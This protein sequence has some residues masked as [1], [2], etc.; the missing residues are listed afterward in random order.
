LT[1]ISIKMKT[2]NYLALCLEQAAQ[3]PLHYRHGA[4]IVRGGKVI[5]KG[6]N[7]YRRGYD[8]GALKTG[9]IAQGA[10]DGPAIAELKHKMKNKDK[11]KDVT[12]AMTDGTSATFVP[13][14]G[15]NGGA[16]QHANTPLSMHSEMMAIHSALAQSSTLASTT[17]SSI[18]PS[19]KLRGKSKRA[20]RLRDEQIKAY[21]EAVC[22]A[23]LE[24][25][26]T[27]KH[28]GKSHVQEWRFEASASQ[29]RSV[30]GQGVSGSEGPIDGAGEHGGKYGETQQEQQWRV[31]EK[32]VS[33]VSESSTYSTPSYWETTR[34]FTVTTCV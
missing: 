13:F 10:F 19:F 6:F 26:A 12:G 32:W 18:K 1:K 25:Q 31:W 23:A 14:E 16:G 24:E 7:D 17:V 30:V 2:D 21:V 4:I 5:G 9:K 8:G 34:T 33:S 28:S 15:I 22:R 3:S 11:P 20:R 29:S 27:Q